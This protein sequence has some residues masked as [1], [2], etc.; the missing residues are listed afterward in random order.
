MV[1]YY[2]TSANKDATHK[3]Q[4]S[5]NVPLSSLRV[6]ELLFFRITVTVLWGDAFHDEA[7]FFL[8]QWMIL[9]W[10]GVWFV[11]IAIGFK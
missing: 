5:S 4:I 6:F 2:T 10:L 1:I 8:A 7:M 9:A 11:K 3:H